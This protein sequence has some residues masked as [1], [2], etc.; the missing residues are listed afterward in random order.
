MV[1]H[2]IGLGAGGH[3]KVV[4]E[5]LRLLPGIELV[6]LLD[7]RPELKGQHLLGLPVLGDDGEL[8][9]LVG[10]GIRHFFVGVGTTGDPTVRHR[11]YELALRHQLQPVDA[12]HPQAI[13]S[14]SARLGQGVTIMAGAIINACVVAGA[15]VVINTGAIIE[16]DCVLGDH[17][18][19]ATGARLT[20]AV[21][22]GNLTHIGAGATIR[23]GIRIG[24]GSIIG[25]GAVVVKDVPAHSLVVGVP[26][27]PLQSRPEGA[28]E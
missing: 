8:P 25:A 9:A 1:T 5:M 12:I 23:Q 24:E 2:V 17:V 27:R 18:H 21:H 13:V 11:L 28:R 4:V 26:A 20:G 10:S 6:G 19:V 14:P 15:N 22:V 7:A 16:H 3:A